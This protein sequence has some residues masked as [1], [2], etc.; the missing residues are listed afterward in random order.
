MP[1]LLPRTVDKFL[2]GVVG[3]LAGWI[4]AARVVPL[5]ILEH[6][7]LVLTTGA[8]RIRADVI[9]GIDR[10]IEKYPVAGDDEHSGDDHPDRMCAKDGSDVVRV[11]P[12]RR[13]LNN[14]RHRPATTVGRGVATVQI[15]PLEV[16]DQA[17]EKVHERQGSYSQ[18]EPSDDC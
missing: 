4:G 1:G 9:A 7:G 15:E 14:W 16:P 18:G 12:E 11:L 17:R 2:V 13:R 5:A 6:L 3:A 8:A 10:T